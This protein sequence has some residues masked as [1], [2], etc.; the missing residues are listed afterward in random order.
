MKYLG[1]LLSLYC[2]ISW[3][4]T[5][6]LFTSASKKIGVTNVNFIRLIFAFILLGITLLISKSYFIPSFSNIHSWFWL[7]L[8]GIIGFIFGDLFLFKSYL[9][10]GFNQARLIMTLVPIFSSIFSFIILKE[11]P[12]FKQSIGIL[13]TV[14]GIIIALHKDKFLKI[15]NIGI[16][17]AC[18][19]ALGQALGLVLSKYGLKNLDAFSGVQIRIFSSIIVFIFILTFQKKCLKFFKAFNDKK[20]IL[21]VFI[22]T[23]I[24]IYLG[25]S[26]GLLALTYTKVSVASTIMATVPIILIPISIFFYKYKISL[27]EIIGTFVSILG[28]SIFFI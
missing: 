16:L 21:N 5:A 2:A 10:I 13:I 8:S 12:S 20:A 1:E 19:G 9:K 18:L 14:L 26:L 23:F 27:K 24:G 17:F 7:S 25:V 11:Q 4:F 15:F 28:I 6:I 22:G 3:A